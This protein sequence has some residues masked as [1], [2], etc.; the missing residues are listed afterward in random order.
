MVKQQRMLQEELPQLQL[1]RLRGPRTRLSGQVCST[2]VYTRFITLKFIRVIYIILVAMIGLV[3]LLLFWLSLASGHGASGVFVALIV[4]PLFTLFCIIVARLAL[5]GI[6]VIFR[7]GENT[8]RIA[9][10]EKA[11]ASAVE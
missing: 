2:S 4:V 11:R 6:A 1:G 8:T 7:I 5:E 3:G 9:N 10:A